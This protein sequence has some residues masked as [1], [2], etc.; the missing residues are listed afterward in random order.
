MKPRAGD[1]V[2][3]K[4]RTVPATSFRFF[5]T[6]FIPSALG[7][8]CSGTESDRYIFPSCAQTKAGLL[9]FS[10][11]LRHVGHSP[12]HDN[13]LRLLKPGMDFLQEVPVAFPEEVIP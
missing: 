10:C 5:S 8:F 1:P 6:R 2:S 7:L 3:W 9:N 11:H 12:R 4:G 13:D